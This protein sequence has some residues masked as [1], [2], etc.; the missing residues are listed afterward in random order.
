MSEERKT[1]GYFSDLEYG[2]KNQKTLASSKGELKTSAEDLQKICAYL[3]EG[4]ELAVMSGW[5]EDILHPKKVIGVGA[6]L[7][8]GV[9][10]WHSDL[11]YY[12]QEY[13]PNLPNS[14]IDH[15]RM[16]GWKIDKERVSAKL[17]STLT[18]V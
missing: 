1:V 8:D 14:F 4:V 3:K 10:E 15:M 12:V 16:N 5:T 6:I 13:Q 17:K 11:A 18:G 7:T 2:E 9:W